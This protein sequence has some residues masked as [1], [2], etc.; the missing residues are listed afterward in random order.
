MSLESTAT[1]ATGSFLHIPLH[2]LSLKTHKYIQFTK[3]VS[4]PYCLGHT[5]TSGN[6]DFMTVGGGIALTMEAMKRIN[7]LL[8]KS[9]CICA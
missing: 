7:R 3:D 5:V 4:Q 9:P 6:L 1:A 2:L 8:N